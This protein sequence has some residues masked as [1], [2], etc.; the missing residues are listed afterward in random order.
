ME[1]K[2]TWQE[3]MAFEAHLGGFNFIIDAHPEFGGQNKGPSPKGLT[4]ISLAGCTGIDVMSILG[5]MR[6]KVDSFEVTTTARLADEHP[7]KFEEIIIKYLF[8]GENLPPK[9]LQ[10]AV[11]LSFDVYCGVLA[12]LKP[13]VKMTWQIYA[14]GKLIA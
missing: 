3:G 6:V 10:D 13:V 2:V 9:K 14:N 12:T 5:K 11:N 1:A 7:K 4:L 8:T